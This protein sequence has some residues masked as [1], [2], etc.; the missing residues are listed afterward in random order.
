M[1]GSRDNPKSP[2]GTDGTSLARGFHDNLAGETRIG[3]GERDPGQDQAIPAIDAAPRPV[4]ASPIRWS[5][6]LAGAAISILFW[7]GIYWIWTAL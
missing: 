4:G 1:G 7:V 2:Q 6:W 5:G 3:A